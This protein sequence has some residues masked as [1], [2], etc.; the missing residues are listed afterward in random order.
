MFPLLMIKSIARRKDSRLNCTHSLY[1][2]TL[3]LIKMILGWSQDTQGSENII[4]W[5]VAQPERPPPLMRQ[6][7]FQPSHHNWICFTIYVDIY[8]L[9]PQI[10]KSSFQLWKK[11]P[12]LALVDHEWKSSMKI[13]KVVQTKNYSN[14]KDFLTHHHPHHGEKVGSRSFERRA[15]HEHG[16]STKNWPIHLPN[17]TICLSSKTMVVGSKSISNLKQFLISF[18]AS[19]TEK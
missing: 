6:R 18:V 3:S 12:T 16:G 14:L 17:C 19:S 13:W 2:L 11:L 9:V 15:S 5:S 10:P 1:I 4:R 7:I 8:Y